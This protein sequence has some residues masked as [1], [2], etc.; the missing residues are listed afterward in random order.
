M[1]TLTASKPVY[2]KCTPNDDGSATMADIVQALPSTNDGKIYIFLGVAYS[3]TAMELHAEH[4]VYYHDG[5]GI[6]IWTGETIVSVDSGLT[7]GTNVNL[8]SNCHAWKVGR[9]CYVTLNLQVTGSISSG[10]ELVKGLPK[11]GASQV[12]FAAALGGSTNSAAM[13]I[14]GSATAITADGAIS[15]T[16]WY[17]A[18]FMYIMG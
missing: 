2:L 4:P 18:F 3:T 11:N 13:R 5:T 17:D 1:K 8:G 7:A 9:M 10:A 16:G 15:Q 12:S 14:Q 6:R